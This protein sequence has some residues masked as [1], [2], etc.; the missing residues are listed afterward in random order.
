M[1]LGQEKILLTGSKCC[2]VKV[3]ADLGGHF[4]VMEEGTR[5]MMWCDASDLYPITRKTLSAMKAYN[6]AAPKMRSALA[7]FRSIRYS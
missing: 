5:Q 6:E 3:M 2:K 4:E 7:M 1:E